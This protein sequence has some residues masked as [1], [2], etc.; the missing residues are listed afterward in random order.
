MLIQITTPQWLSLPTDVRSKLKVVFG[1]PRSEGAR[2]EDNKVMSDGHNHRDL[3]AI[4][5]EKMQDY[6]GSK[7]Q[8]FFK[9]FDLTLDKIQAESSTTVEQAAPTQPEVTEHLIQ[10]NGKTYKLTEVTAAP[11][12][13]M[14]APGPAAPQEAAQKPAR[15]GRKAAQTGGVKKGGTKAAK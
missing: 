8:D 11:A 3:T 6:T 5:V 14:A 13:P 1:I 9:L 7:Q 4:T 2:I 10:F 12:A 15:V